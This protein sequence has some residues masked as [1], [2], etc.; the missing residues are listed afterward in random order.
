MF[1][2]MTFIA[3]VDRRLNAASTYQCFLEAVFYPRSQCHG[4]NQ[5]LLD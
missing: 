5:I 1:A 4:D 3:I 2:P